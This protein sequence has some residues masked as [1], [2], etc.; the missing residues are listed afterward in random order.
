M[1]GDRR[2]NEFSDLLHSTGYA[3]VAME[4]VDI[5]IIQGLDAHFIRG[6][7]GM[8]ILVE[9][10]LELIAYVHRVVL[11]LVISILGS[12]IVCPQGLSYVRE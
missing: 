9:S 1:R 3:P 8:D 6:K 5:L 11:F 4:S 10:A 7:E 12:A 2:L